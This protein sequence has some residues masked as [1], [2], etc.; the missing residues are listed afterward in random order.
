MCVALALSLFLP[1]VSSAK[2]SCGSTPTDT[3]SDEYGYMTRVVGP[4]MSSEFDG[5]G[6][7]K[8]W[9]TYVANN[10]LSRTALL[11]VGWYWIDQSPGEIITFTGIVTITVM[12]T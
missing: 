4:G 1:T 7:L 2:L 11:G 6:L 10:V 12:A 3:S 9:D 5:E 8:Q